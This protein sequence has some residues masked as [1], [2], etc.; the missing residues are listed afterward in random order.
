MLSSTKHAHGRNH[1]VDIPRATVASRSLHLIKIAPLS[2][3]SH[4][5]PHYHHGCVCKPVSIL[6]KGLRQV[7]TERRSIRGKPLRVQKMTATATQRGFNNNTRAKT[8]SLFQSTKAQAAFTCGCGRQCN[9]NIG[10]PATDSSSVTLGILSRTGQ[11]PPELL[12]HAKHPTPHSPMPKHQT[13]T[14]TSHPSRACC[15]HQVGR[16]G[17]HGC[18]ATDPYS[19]VDP[20]SHT[21][22]IPDMAPDPACHHAHA[23]VYRRDTCL[24][25]FS[26]PL[27]GLSSRMHEMLGGGS[28]AETNV[29]RIFQRHARPTA[30]DRIPKNEI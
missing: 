9:T 22:S 19:H 29:A 6:R 11:H 8:S 12:F 16:P 1:H 28:S 24:S 20:C 15:M 23:G 27:L 5:N 13:L 7:L 21:H 26:N 10:G 18:T 17:A 3:M 25:P 14:L 30:H 4:H 2:P